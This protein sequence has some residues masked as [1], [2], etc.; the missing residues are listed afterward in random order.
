M[1][2]DENIKILKQRYAK[3]EITKRQF[4]QMKTDLSEGNISEATE[5]KEASNSND[6]ATNRFNIS[7][8]GIPIAIII[9]LALL[10]FFFFS[11]NQNQQT[12]TT[13]TP[14]SQQYTTTYNPSSISSQQTTT[15]TT[16]IAPQVLGQVYCIAGD[17]GTSGYNIN[18]VYNTNL[19]SSGLGAWK[20]DV[21]YPLSVDYSSCVQYNNQV[22]CVGGEQ[23]VGS[24]YQNTNA[25]YYSSISG[26]STSNWVYTTQY[27]VPIWMHSC[28]TSNGYIYCIG[29][30]STA[31]TTNN[32]SNYYA[33]LTS[34]GI[35]Q[36]QKTT[37]YTSFAMLE[38]CVAYNSYIYC[39]G[40]YSGTLGPS[41][42]TSQ[43]FYAP[44]TPSGI[45][46]WQTSS[47]YPSKIVR[48]ACVQNNSYIYCVGGSNSNGFTEQ[49][50]YAPISAS[51]I[52]QWQTTT[53]YPTSIGE[54]SGCVAK[55]NY[56]YCVGG[57]GDSESPVNYAYYASLSSSGIGQW[58]S[59]TSYPVQDGV[60]S[61]VT[62]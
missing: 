42:I 26:N 4:E 31:W 32:N 62:N 51:G 1:I 25:T 60:Q 45:G 6:S 13:S 54:L 59:A 19:T 23:A 49:A 18:A 15:P 2:D 40:G 8:F 12:Y 47:N 61:C 29:G 14:Q 22:Y 53:S 30:S 39:V 16:T 27:P 20:S 5:P 28:V 33:P 7:K 11:N 37:S 43:T 52:G 3:G 46:Q 38:S 9:V 41:S 17:S 48:P 34:Y 56:I 50:Y 44:L 35:G 55:N 36:W 10:F 21:S 24:Q 57:G 58:Q